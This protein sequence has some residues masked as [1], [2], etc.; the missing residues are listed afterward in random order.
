MRWGLTAEPFDISSVLFSPRLVL[1]KPTRITFPIRIPKSRHDKRFFRDLDDSMYIL[2]FIHR[3]LEPSSS[4]KRHG[5][6]ERP[7]PTDLRRAA[8]ALIS[9]SDK[10]S[11]ASFARGLADFGVELV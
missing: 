1:K 10:T 6:S 7:M 9:V 11:L 2:E 3:A 5:P 8:R 4:F